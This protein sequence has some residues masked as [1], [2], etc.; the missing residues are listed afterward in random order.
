MQK[1]YLHEVRLKKKKKKGKR[2]QRLQ[3]NKK[4]KR[5]NTKIKALNATQIDF[6]LFVCLF[7]C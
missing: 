7:V 2:K 4:K 1:D 3:V 6:L 5:E